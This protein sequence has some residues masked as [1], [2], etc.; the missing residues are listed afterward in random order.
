MTRRS[1]LKVSGAAALASQLSSAAEVPAGGRLKQSV[2][3][4]TYKNFSVD[5]LCQHAVKIGLKGIDLVESTDWP[6]IQ[7]YG[8]TPSM[9]PGAGTIPHGFNRRDQHDQL[10]QEMEK[11]IA[12]ASEA[13]VPNVITF[14][15][16]RAGMADGEA[17]ENCVIGLN[18]CK[19]LAEE[20]GVTIN[21]ELLNSK[22]DHK[23][24]Q[25]DH[26]AWGVEVMKKV[27]SP[28][29]KLL[30]DIYHMQIM[31]GDIVRTIRNNIAYLGHFHTGGVPGRHEIDQ[32]QELNWRFVAQAIADLNFQGFIAHEFVPAAKDQIA[33][34]QQAY[35]ICKV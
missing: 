5:E 18:R 32:T 2:S 8:L 29:V 34:L 19:K 23:D 15:G 10:V 27:D 20:K 1:L 3:K 24:Y 30:F 31:E 14:S 26:T 35:E 7:K 25:C 4:W 21:M 17:I 16:N 22:V 13:K 33:S 9:T 12:K 28:R 6:T 11:N